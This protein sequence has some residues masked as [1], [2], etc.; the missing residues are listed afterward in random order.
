MA[1]E[2]FELVNNQVRPSVHALLI[3]PFKTIWEND[4]SENKEEAYKIFKYIEFMCSPKKSNSFFGYSEEERP[5][6]LK[7]AIWGDNPPQD[8]SL[9]IQGVTV[10]KEKMTEASVSYSLYNSS[11]NAA[12]KLKDYLDSFDLEE[13]TRGGT[14][15]IKP[16]EITSALKEIP[17]VIKSIIALKDK[18][19]YELVEETKTR[20]QR[21]IGEYER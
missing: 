16:K 20:N 19:H 17:D 18:V 13:R 14:A 8:G 7:K 21:Q 15:V 3:E 5:I 4:E 1:F 12:H 11:L 6:K 10:Y 2:L 9:I